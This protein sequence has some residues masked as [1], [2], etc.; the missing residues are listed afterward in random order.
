VKRLLLLTIII[1]CFIS[2]SFSQCIDNSCECVYSLAINED[3]LWI[4]TKVGLY[5]YDIMTGTKILYNTKNSQL[6]NN[7][8]YALKLGTD[9]LLWIGTYGGGLANLKNG[10]WTIYN[11]TNSSIASNN[12]FDVEIVQDSILWL[13]SD[14]GVITYN[15]QDWG[16]FNKEN[17]LLTY[18]LV[19]STA[20]EGDSVI[21]ISANGGLSKYNGTWHQYT[22]E[23][24]GLP[25]NIVYTTEIIGQSKY[26]G[27]MEGLATFNGYVWNTEFSEKT[28]VVKYEDSNGNIWAGTSSGL[29]RSIVDWDIT[30]NTSNSI[31]TNNY[32]QDLVIDKYGNKW[33]ATWGGGVYRFD[34]TDFQKIDILT[35]VVQLK[36]N[37]NIKVFPNPTSELLNLEFSSMIEDEVKIDLVNI[38]GNI[39]KSVTKE[40]CNNVVSIDMSNFKNGIM[41]LKIYQNS[42][43]IIGKIIKQ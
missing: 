20:N 6:P 19:Y 11:K 29:K 8:V 9:N 5:K 40:V 23:N 36:S 1:C 28:L 10:A 12:I 26:I 21:W 2:N 18:D 22:R 41:I 31:L 37:S 30:Y 3:T 7:Y 32:I 13:A 24:S 43:M 14:K 38:R 35:S 27:T 39:L 34:N 16:L 33:I 15:S 4:G 42:N 25:H 17:S